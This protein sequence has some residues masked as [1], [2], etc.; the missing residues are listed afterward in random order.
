MQVLTNY[1]ILSSLSFQHTGPLF[2]ISSL[3][4]SD[5]SAHTLLSNV[6]SKLT[7][8][9]LQ[10]FLATDNSIPALLIPYINVDFRVDIVLDY[11]TSSSLI[12][13][14]MLAQVCTKISTAFQ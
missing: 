5:L 7:H 3:L 13:S 11:V 12:N 10:A 4:I 9:L 6:I 14:A 1:N 8:P 2:V